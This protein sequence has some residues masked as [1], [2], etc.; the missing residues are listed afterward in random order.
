MDEY[1]LTITDHPSI[2][3]DPTRPGEKLYKDG[4]P[5]PVFPDQRCLRFN[6][7]AIAFVSKR[8]TGELMVSFFGFGGTLPQSV[9]DEAVALAETEFNQPVEKAYQVSAIQPAPDE[10]DE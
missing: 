3:D 8:N 1:E 4:K 9:K 7:Q 5:V 10:D 6:G 2:A